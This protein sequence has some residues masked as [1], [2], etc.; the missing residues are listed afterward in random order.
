MDLLDCV[1]NGCLQHGLGVA[2]SRGCTGL[3]HARDSGLVSD[4]V[5]RV[6]CVGSWKMKDLKVAGPVKGRG[7]DV[8][9]CYVCNCTYYLEDQWDCLDGE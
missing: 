4:V 7:T 8:V 5:H 6:A 3:R 1:T 2:D 9:P